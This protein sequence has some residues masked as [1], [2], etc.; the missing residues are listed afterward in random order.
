MPTVEQNSSVW[1]ENYD[2]SQSGDEW[3]SV[4]GGPEAQWFG[5][6]F[7]RI[8]AFLPTETIL[9]IAPGF[10]R[11][12]QFLAHYA[13][14]LIVV[15][16]SERCIETCKKRFSRWSHIEYH[17]ND[18]KSLDFL[19]DQSVDFVFSFDSLVHAEADVLKDY[20]AQLAARLKRNGAGFIHHSNLASYVDPLTKQLPA[21]VENQHW[22]AT[23]MSADLFRDFCETA[24]LECVT[25]EKVNWGA[26]EL[27]D[28]FSTF[29]RAGSSWSRPNRVLENAQFMAEAHSISRLAPLYSARG[30]AGPK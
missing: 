6:I 10:G 15:D 19:T 30:W 21:G 16:L 20:L 22:R 17:V 8:H 23:S 28:S 3:S 24:N 5:A 18:G 26:S 29:T 27:N 12:T 2:W 1:N 13:K 11:W 25:Q 4:W 7:P 14:R 9:E